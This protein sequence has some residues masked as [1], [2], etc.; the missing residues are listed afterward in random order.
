MPFARSWPGPPTDVAPRL[1][2][3]R[4]ARCP[5]AGPMLRLALLLVCL[6]GLSNG[7]GASEWQA[8]D[9]DLRAALEARVGRGIPVLDRFAFEVWSTT[10]FAR[11]QRFLPDPAR[12]RELLLSLWGHA[13]ANGLDPDFVLALIEVESGFDRFAISTAGAQGLMQ[14]MPF[15]KHELGRAADNL[16]RIDT[17]LDYGT[18]ILAHYLSV[19]DGDMV[20][21]LQRYHGNR[22]SLDYADRVF[23]AWHRRW[24]T[25]TDTEVMQ[26]LRQ[27]ALRRVPA[28]TVVR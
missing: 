10:Q 26:V 8:P 14:V 27:C 18:T 4:T 5:M 28:C 19:A 12:R 25:G 15:W 21:A 3:P 20:G 6:A 7:T 23:T 17:N 1:P 11:L 24:R 13:R 2:G 9:P 22:R 16:A